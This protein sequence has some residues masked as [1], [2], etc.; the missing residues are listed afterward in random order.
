MYIHIHAGT[1]HDAL[2]AAT[3]LDGVSL[4]DI[5][6]MSL[7]T[8]PARSPSKRGSG[9]GSSSDTF[10]RDVSLSLADRIAASGIFFELL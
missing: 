6:A 1:Q 3:A 7:G 2:L 5:V 4:H 10:W 9:S 8:S